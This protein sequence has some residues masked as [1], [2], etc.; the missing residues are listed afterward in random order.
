MAFRPFKSL[1]VAVFSLFLV[2]F[3]NTALAG[4]GEGA[5]AK[6]DPG[7]EMLDHIADAH[8]FHF[9]TIKKED[10][11]RIAFHVIDCKSRLFVKALHGCPF[12]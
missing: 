5:E 12:L 9:F 6:F 3:S 7:K 2:L 10:G 1:S 11:F 8:E 4:E